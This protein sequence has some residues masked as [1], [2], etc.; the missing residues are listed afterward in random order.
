MDRKKSDASPQPKRFSSTAP[1]T[2][3]KREPAARSDLTPPSRSLMGEN[4]VSLLMELVRRAG[5][6]SRADL[7]RRSQLSAPTVSTIIDQLLRRGIDRKS[8]RLNPSHLG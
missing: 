1:K 4:N 8:T 2:A 3:M 7:A 5:S 6:I